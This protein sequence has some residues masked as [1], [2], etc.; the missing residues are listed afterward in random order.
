MRE[1][2]KIGIMISAIIARIAGRE[3][4]TFLEED[5]RFAEVRE[6]LIDK[7]GLDLDTFISLESDEISAYVAGMKNISLVNLELLADLIKEIGMKSGPVVSRLYLERAVILYEMCISSD[8][9]FSFEREMKIT[10]L[11]NYLSGQKNDQNPFHGN[12]K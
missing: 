5:Q 9:T 6:E 12:A 3:V 11:R 7:I 1:I 8:R 10:E 4:R 2:E